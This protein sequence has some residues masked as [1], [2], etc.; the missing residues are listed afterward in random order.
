[1]TAERR[2]RLRGAQ[3]EPRLLPAG[4]EGLGSPPPIGR[5]CQCPLDGPRS[6]TALPLGVI[7]RRMA[8]GGPVSLMVLPQG[9]PHQPDHLIA[10]I[11]P[12]MTLDFFA[13]YR[14]FSCRLCTGLQLE[15]ENPNLPAPLPAP[16]PNHDPNQ[17]EQVQLQMDP[18]PPVP[19]H[20][21]VPP[22]AGPDAARL[23]LIAAI[24]RIRRDT[25]ED[26]AEVN[27]DENDDEDED[28]DGG[29]GQGQAVDE[30]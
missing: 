24:E 29:E 11:G 30:D 3:L 27:E 8:E 26:G 15:I 18:P 1:M 28:E 9:L 25:R 14:S 21:P 13:E 10:Q 7:A 19:R 20:G 23:L 2:S 17:D 12:G 5:L 4:G 16:E 22:A 6:E